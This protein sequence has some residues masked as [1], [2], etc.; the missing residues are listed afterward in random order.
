MFENAKIET[1]RLIIRSFIPRDSIEM[2]KVLN[3]KKVLK[4]LNYEPI[5]LINVQTNINKLISFYLKNSCEKILQQSMAV[6]LKE[7]N[8]LIGWC[9]FGELEYDKSQIELYYTIASSHWNLGYASESALAVLK[10]V[11]SI[12]KLNEI[13]AVINPENLA[14]I[15]VVEKIGLKYVGIEEN[16][17]DEY[18]FYKGF[19]KYHLSRIKYQNL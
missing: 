9:G 2:H 17:S 5:E 18:K 12:V 6:I 8:E 4:F 19:K 7:T 3:D 11:F 14:S 13:V 15:R 1:K 10:Y 16:V